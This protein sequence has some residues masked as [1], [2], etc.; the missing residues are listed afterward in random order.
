MS[1]PV[2]AIP[3]N[4]ETGLAAIRLRNALCG[5]GPQ[6]EHAAEVQAR[7][8]RDWPTLWNALDD[9]M[10]A[11]FPG[12]EIINRKGGYRNARGARPRTRT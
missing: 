1:A 6:P 8:R 5:V 11:T 12:Q 4:Y 2:V 7:H 10:A 9:L 3:E